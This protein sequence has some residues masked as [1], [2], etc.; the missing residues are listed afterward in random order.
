MIEKL[1]EFISY[2]VFWLYFGFLFLLGLAE[3]ILQWIIHIVGRFILTA[4]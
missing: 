4:Q 3:T 2:C 1:L